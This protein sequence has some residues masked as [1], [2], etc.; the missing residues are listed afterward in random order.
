MKKFE[1]PELEVVVMDVRD[2][3]TTSDLPENDTDIG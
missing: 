1:T 3:V 2:V